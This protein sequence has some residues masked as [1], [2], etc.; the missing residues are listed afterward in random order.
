MNYKV[1]VR[2]PNKQIVSARDMEWGDAGII[3][4]G[5]RAGQVVVCVFHPE[6][7]EHGLILVNLNDPKHTNCLES[8]E[9][10]PEFTVSVLQQGESIEL[11]GE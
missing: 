10:P 11:V 8:L 3:S 4:E 2:S 5:P 1:N 6:P 7:G 9:I